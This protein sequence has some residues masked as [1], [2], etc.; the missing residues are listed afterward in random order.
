MSAWRCLVVTADGLTDWRE[1]DAPSED[2][3]LARLS[4]EGVTPLEVMRSGGSLLA[5]L[6]QPVL[7]GHKLSVADQALLLSRLATLVGSGLPV[8]RSLDLL[9]EQAAR[10]KQR[11]ILARML[12][13]VREGGGLGRAQPPGGGHDGIQRNGVS[14]DIEGRF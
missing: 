10:S 14:A 12:V 5:R 1:I 13:T 3:L 4:S 7:L 8:D 9:R 6:N 11:A 2:A